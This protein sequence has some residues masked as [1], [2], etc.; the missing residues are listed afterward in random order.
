M[1]RE[2]I[3]DAVE[4]LEVQRCVCEG[5]RVDAAVAYAVGEGIVAVS[6]TP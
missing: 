4:V 1:A 5:A 6:V 3:G 2:E